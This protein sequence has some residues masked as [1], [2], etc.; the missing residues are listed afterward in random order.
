MN[1]VVMQYYQFKYL[2]IFNNFIY[3]FK[4]I[5]N[6][7]ILVCY[8]WEYIVYEEYTGAF[9]KSYKNDGDWCKLFAKAEGYIKTVFCEDINNPKRFV[10][11]DYWESKELL[12]KFKAD[13]E[14]EYESIDSKCEEYIEIEVFV[15]D[16]LITSDS[17]ESMNFYDVFNTK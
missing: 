17:S 13:F 8:I 2:F 12:F 3:T 10:T 1:Y 4:Q 5:S 11:I 6:K 16:F 7:V 15:G 9:K 14:D